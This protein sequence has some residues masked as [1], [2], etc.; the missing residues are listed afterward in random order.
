MMRA[1]ILQEVQGYAYESPKVWLKCHVWAKGLHSVLLIVSQRETCVTVLG[2]RIKKN[3][4]YSP[5]IL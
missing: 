3:T 2:N 1:S 4:Y 5:L